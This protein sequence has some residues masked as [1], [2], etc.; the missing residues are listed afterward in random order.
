M[1]QSEFNTSQQINETCYDLVKQGYSLHDIYA[2]LTNVM[3]GIKPQHVS[4][5]P[6]TL[7]VDIN[8]TELDRKLKQ[9]TRLA[10]DLHNVLDI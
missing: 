5:E 10:K 3:H 2:G 6:I 4:T 7:L 8:T 9:S 1:E